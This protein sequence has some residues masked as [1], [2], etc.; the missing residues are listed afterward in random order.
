MPERPPPM[1]GIK[2]PQPDRQ[3]PPFTRGQKGL[4]CKFRIIDRLLAYALGMRRPSQFS[5]RNH[6]SRQKI[7]VCMDRFLIW[8]IAFLT[9]RFVSSEVCL[10]GQSPRI[11]WP[12]LCCFLDHEKLHCALFSRCSAGHSLPTKQLTHSTYRRIQEAGLFRR[13]MKVGPTSAFWL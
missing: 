8:A 13:P 2:T 6:V 11:C 4:P 9:I 1:A 10:I 5:W 3:K 7:Y 12:C